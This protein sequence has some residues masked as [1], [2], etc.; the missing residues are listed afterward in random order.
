MSTVIKQ[1]KFSAAIAIA[2]IAT[3]CTPL[4]NTYY[5][6]TRSSEIIIGNEKRLKNYQ[7]CPPAFVVEELSIIKQFALNDTRN[8]QLQSGAIAEVSSNQCTYDN[9]SVTIDTEIDFTATLG[10]KGRLMNI[11]NPIYTY[12]F[13]VA[14]T[15]RSGKILTKQLFS[16]SINFN[17]G[18]DNGTYKETLRQI[19][20]I[21]NPDKASQYAVMVGFQLTDEQLDYNRTYLREKKR[22]ESRAAKEQEKLHKE[23]EDDPLLILK[24][25]TP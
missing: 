3:S 25:Q 24:G 22:I 10:P 8:S 17:N 14:I 4:Q 23:Q 18:S 6:I 9:K 12:P 16:A 2:L 5:G 19:I 11:D 15:G 21:D 7:K 13:F 1:I 20:P